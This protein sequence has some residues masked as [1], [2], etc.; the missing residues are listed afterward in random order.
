VGEVG[1]QFIHFV[2]ESDQ[3]HTKSLR[4]SPNGFRLWLDTCY[5]VKDHH[6]TIEDAQAALNLNCKINVSR[7][8]YDV[9]LMIPPEARHRSS[10]DGD[11]SL[12]LLDHPVGNGRSIIDRPHPMGSPCV[13]EHSL[14]GSRL[15]RIDVSDDTDIANALQG[16]GHLLH[17]LRIEPQ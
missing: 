13:K 2:N 12:P 1:A 3:R 7:R 11:S 4:L 5:S 10:G 6:P 17:P 8:I 9:N 15:P 14:S 16:P